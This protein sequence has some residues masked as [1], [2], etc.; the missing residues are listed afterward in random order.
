MLMAELALRVAQICDVGGVAGERVASVPVLAFDSVGMG[1]PS[2]CARSSS[3]AD[4][5]LVRRD[6]VRVAVEL[7]AS[8]TPNL[9]AK[10]ARWARTLAS[11]PFD[12]SGLVV[13]FVEAGRVRLLRVGCVGVWR[14]RLACIR[15]ARR[16]GWRSGCL[17]RRGVTGFPNLSG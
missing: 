12:R 9:D 17:W 16:T 8:A 4:A 5:V 6:G 15:V 10:T 3:C 1:R 7:T 14:G 2:W 11:S 13:V